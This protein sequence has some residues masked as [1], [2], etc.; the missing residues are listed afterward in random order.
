MDWKDEK[1]YQHLRM[2]IDNKAK[3]ITVDSEM[4]SQVV[5]IPK[6]SNRKFNIAGYE[7]IS[8]Q[9]CKNRFKFRKPY[10]FVYSYNVAIK[11]PIS[12]LLYSFITSDFS[13]R[14]GFEKFI[15]LWGLPGLLNIDT[16]PGTL[17][18]EYK[19][20]CFEEA[21]QL[22]DDFYLYTKESLITAQGDFRQ[23]IDYC[24]NT[25]KKPHLKV[26]SPSK[27]YFV[28]VSSRSIPDLTIYS[29]SHYTTY[30]VAGVYIDGALPEDV[31]CADI[32]DKTL[33]MVPTCHSQNIIT[34]VY[35]ELFNLLE[36]FSLGKCASCDEYFV[37]T[38]SSEVYCEKCRDI[39]YL[40]K[41]KN[42]ELLKA[43]NTAYKT[44]HAQKQRHSGANSSPETKEK[45][46]IALEN[47][48][49]EAKKKFKQVQQEEIS[50][51]K[52]YNFLSSDLEV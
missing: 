32:K 13:T 21:A 35:I 38:R 10:F 7:T 40:N 30:K 51:E 5:G 42:D 2:T 19:Y 14:E 31:L 48:R 45:Y 50:E 3:L 26:L 37:P 29:T 41:V 17:K 11:K 44:K 18:Y 25:N 22:I 49:E 39:G 9:G 20:Y 15:N 12:T 8:K 47:W 1:N 28:G 16:P 43:Y 6:G 33:E 52:F 36:N 24:I 23:V 46:K 34:L 4:I 27:R